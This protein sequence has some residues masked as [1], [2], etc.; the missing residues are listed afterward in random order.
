MM[1]ESI[2]KLMPKRGGGSCLRFRLSEATARSGRGTPYTGG[3]RP[4]TATG[5]AAREPDAIKLRPS[6]PISG[7]TERFPAGRTR[8]PR[9]RV[10]GGGAKETPLWGGARERDAALGRGLTSW[11]PAKRRGETLWSKDPKAWVVQSSVSISEAE[12]GGV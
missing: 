6:Q 8:E 1:L 3:L 2:K 9:S 12:G 11:G 5:A 7:R 10:S 4:R